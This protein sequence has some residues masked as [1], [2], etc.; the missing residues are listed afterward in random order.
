[1]GRNLY[2]NCK[3]LSGTSMDTINPLLIDPIPY[4]LSSKVLLD[5]TAFKTS[6]EVTHQHEFRWTEEACKLPEG[7]SSEPMDEE[8][9][10]GHC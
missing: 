8:T 3:K 2:S 5:I 7:L 10:V 6:K 9:S 4:L 1:M